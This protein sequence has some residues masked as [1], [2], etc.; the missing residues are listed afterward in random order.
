MKSI[1][2]PSFRYVPAR[3]TD[4]AETFRRARSEMKPERDEF[5]VVQFFPDG[6]YEYTRRFVSVEEA[7]KAFTHYTTS[8]GARM[9]TTVRVIITDGGD[10]TAA[11]WIYGKGITF[12]HEGTP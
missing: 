9:G 11:E 10:C 2:D 6:S 4:V 8:V 5:S 3:D 12:P 1:L 7:G